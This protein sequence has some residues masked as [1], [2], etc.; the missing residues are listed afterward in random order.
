[1]FFSDLVSNALSL[2]SP[3]VK[4]E[5]K[6]Q[7]LQLSSDRVDLHKIPG[8]FETGTVDGNFSGS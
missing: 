6:H 7:R 5:L 3:I 1:M 4:S 2:S 8:H